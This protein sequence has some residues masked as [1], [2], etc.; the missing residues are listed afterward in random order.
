MS[1]HGYFEPTIA[2]YRSTGKGTL[3]TQPTQLNTQVVLDLAESIKAAIAAGMPPVAAEQ[4]ADRM[5]V[6]GRADAGVNEY[7]YNNPRA[8]KLAETLISQGYSK[9]AAAFAAAMLDKSEVAKRLNKPLDEVWNGVG[10][11]RETGRT[12]KQHAARSAAHA[13]AATAP[14]NAQFLALVKRAIEHGRT[15]AEKYYKELP[16]LETPPPLTGG[17]IPLANG[18]DQYDL[19]ASIQWQ[20]DADAN[21]FITAIDETSPLY[22]SDVV[23]ELL[24][25]YNRRKRNLPDPA[26][27]T[28]YFQNPTAR[29]LIEQAIVHPQVVKMLEYFLTTPVPAE[30]AK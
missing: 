8:H 6:E 28:H 3:E 21:K 16:S 18:R 13:G 24:T 7:N 30:K 10:R 9:V 12:G 27:L 25:L 23:A 15:P 26:S 1:D 2:G 4:L 11:S 5:L 19:L 20:G 29:S 17:K 14:Q 22:A